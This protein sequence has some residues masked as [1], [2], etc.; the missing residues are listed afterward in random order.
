MKYFRTQSAIALLTILCTTVNVSPAWG[1]SETSPF[2]CVGCNLRGV[3]MGTE[4]YLGRN[5]S[6]AILRDADLRGANLSN[7]VLMGA[8][9][10]GADLRNTILTNT[11]FT[12]SANLQNL[13]IVKVLDLLSKP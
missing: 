11:F 4:E 10:R 3:D 6:G 5:L 7:V 2:E 9:L 1:Q 13:Y 8:D 12:G